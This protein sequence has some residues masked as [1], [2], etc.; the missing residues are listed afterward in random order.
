[1]AS[2]YVAVTGTPPAS[3]GTDDR[4][5]S[6]QYA[7]SPT[8]VQKGKRLLPLAVILLNTG[9]VGLTGRNYMIILNSRGKRS[10][11]M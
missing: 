4:Y 1:M 9:Y 11:E 5:G 6:L 7:C 8:L 2:T 3:W 10:K